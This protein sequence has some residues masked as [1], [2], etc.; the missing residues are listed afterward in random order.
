MN[1][2]SIDDRT[3]LELEKETPACRAK[4]TSANLNSE[5]IS[6]PRLGGLHHRYNPAAY[7]ID[8]PIPQCEFE[9]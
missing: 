9:E 7:I 3:H 5:I 8:F 6:M 2:S 1:T 4:A